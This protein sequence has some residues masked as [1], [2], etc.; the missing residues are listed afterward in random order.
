MSP[1]HSVAAAPRG[2]PITRGPTRSTIF[3]DLHI[4]P[5]NQCNL[6]CEACICTFERLSANVPARVTLDYELY[7]KSLREIKA[8]GLSVRH[9]A[10]VGFGEPLFNTRTPDMAR[11]GRQL[12]PNANIFV[13]TNANFGKRRA[14]E[15]ACCGLSQ[16]RLSLLVS[17]RPPTNSTAE[18]AN[19]RG[20]LIVDAAR[21]R[22]TPRP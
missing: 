17:I 1:F 7:E 5:S 13:D 22:Y 19:G 12:F 2:S 4:E 20:L 11:L 6:Y 3:I 18:T 21:R 14:E 8:A 10:L 9:L 15:L 16:I